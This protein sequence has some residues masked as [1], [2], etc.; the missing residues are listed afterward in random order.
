MPGTGSC[1]PNFRCFSMKPVRRGRANPDLF[2]ER[3]DA[4][5]NMRPW[6]GSFGGAAAMVGVR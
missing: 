6:L 2:R 3:L 5:I 1:S 4:I